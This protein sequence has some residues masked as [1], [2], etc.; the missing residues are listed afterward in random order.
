ME[1]STSGLSSSTYPIE[2]CAEFLSSGTT[3]TPNAEDEVLPLPSKLHA[4]KDSTVTQAKG[5]SLVICL[6]GTG[7]N[8]GYLVDQV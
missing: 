1:H 3:T 8:L 6:D 4:V 5:R 2:S 7:R